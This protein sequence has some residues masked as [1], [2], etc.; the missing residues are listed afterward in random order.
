ML[1]FNVSLTL[2]IVLLSHTSAEALNL[3]SSPKDKLKALVAAHDQ[4]RIIDEL[5]AKIRDSQT[6]ALKP[7]ATDYNKIKKE[8]DEI[9]MSIKQRQDELKKIIEVEIKRLEQEIKQK[10]DLIQAA[11]T[12]IKNDREKIPGKDIILNLLAGK[13]DTG[14]EVKNIASKGLKYVWEKFGSKVNEYLK[15]VGFPKPFN[16]YKSSEEIISDWQRSLNEEKQNL[17]KALGFKGQ[18]ET[19]PKLADYLTSQLNKNSN[20]LLEWFTGSQK[21]ENERQVKQRIEEIIALKKKA[22]EHY[23]NLSNATGQLGASTTNIIRTY[24]DQAKLATDTALKSINKAGCGRLKGLNDLRSETLKA[25]M[26]EQLQKVSFTKVSNLGEC[27]QLRT[28]TQ[29]GK[30]PKSTKITEQF[31]LNQ[32]YEKVLACTKAYITK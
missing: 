12:A 8:Y 24:S 25:C 21:R 17:Q 27:Y 3:F 28:T 14:S 23:M 16:E 6:K 2:S 4:A 11:E 29:V 19:N 26:F 13:L 32:P 31:D 30:D 7:A 1:R 18:L 9:S 5:N 20:G 15:S 22:A 10:T